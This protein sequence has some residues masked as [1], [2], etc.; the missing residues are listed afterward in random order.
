MALDHDQNSKGS[1]TPSVIFKCNI[2]SETSGSFY[3]GQ[4]NVIIKDT[5]LRPST[6]V[7]HAVKL[8]AV[9][10]GHSLPSHD[11]PPVLFAY[12]DG[13]GDHH[14]TF[15]SVQLSWILLFYALDLDM[16]VTCGTAPG[17]SYVHPTE[18]CMTV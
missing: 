6:R 12:T 13:G 2:P 1:L 14:C 3:Q 11:V 4:L 18:R 7:Q 15:L 9:L 16:L 8:H 10:R 17:H 5:V